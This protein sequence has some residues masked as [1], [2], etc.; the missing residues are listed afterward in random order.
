MKTPIKL[1]TFI[2]LIF[3]LSILTNCNA[4]NPDKL[5]IRKWKWTDIKS[6]DLDKEAAKYKAMLDTCKNEDMKLQCENTIKFLA[7]SMDALKTTEVD[8]QKGGKMLMKMSFF[9]KEQ[10]LSGTWKLSK[11][12]KK[13]AQTSDKNKSTEYDIQELSAD[14]MILYGEIGNKKMGTI[15]LTPIK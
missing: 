4:V 8:F 14:K 1:V 10:S 5:L 2:T 9:G 3:N 11:D 6:E 13:L 15:T 7:A 12:K